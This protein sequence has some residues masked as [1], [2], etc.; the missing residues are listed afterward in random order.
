MQGI[1]EIRQQIGV[2]DASQ[3]F[4]GGPQPCGKRG[5]IVT[6][7]SQR[8]GAEAFFHPQRIEVGIDQRFTVGGRRGH[9]R[10]P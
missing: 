4:A 1:R 6:I 5:E 8:I 10:E 9:G 3:G 2:I 7:G